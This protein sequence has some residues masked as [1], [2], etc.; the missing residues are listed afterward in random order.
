M[1]CTGEMEAGSD[2]ERADGRAGEVEAGSNGERA[3]GR[4]GEVEAG[5]NGKRSRAPEVEAGGDE[6]RAGREA[7]VAERAR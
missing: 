2:D 7:M 3:C 6:G 5:I 4:A 1:G